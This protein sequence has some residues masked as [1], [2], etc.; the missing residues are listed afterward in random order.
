MR[1][2]LPLAE[3]GFL[4]ENP[5]FSTKHLVLETRFLWDSTPTPTGDLHQ[6]WRR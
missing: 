2:V 5:R 4:T 1:S 3:T 6:I